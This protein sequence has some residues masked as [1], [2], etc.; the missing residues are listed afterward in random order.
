MTSTHGGSKGVSVGN[1]VKVQVVLASAVG[2][3]HELETYYDRKF[4]T[5]AFVSVPVG[6][7]VAAGMVAS[8]AGAPRPRT[9]VELV[10]AGRKYITWTDAQGRYAF[11]SRRLKPG[12]YELIVDGKRQPLKLEGKRVTV[13]VT[14][15]QRAGVRDTGAVRRSPGAERVEVPPRRK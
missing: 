11:R 13:N 10:T 12:S 6:D 9:R 5:F 8:E 2:E 14:V 7:T 3:Y 4:G 1:T 15:D